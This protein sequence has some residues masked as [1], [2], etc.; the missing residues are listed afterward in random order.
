[1]SGLLSLQQA[2][3]QRITSQN[4]LGTMDGIKDKDE[5]NQNGSAPPTCLDCTLHGGGIGEAMET[6]N[7]G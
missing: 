1:M 6:G 7:R 3:P 4:S 2:E 5:R